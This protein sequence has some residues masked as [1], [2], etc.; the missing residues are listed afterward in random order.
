MTSQGSPIARFRR[1]VAT[2]NPLIVHAAAAEASPLALADALRY[3]LVLA[4]ADPSRYPPA[5]ARFLALGCR[6]L[7][8]TLAD[9]QFAAACLGGLC[10]P[11]RPG[12]G[13][14]L[15]ELLR[16]Q[17]VEAARVLSAWLDADLD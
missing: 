14:G 15:L 9:A 10:A 1:A 12:A 11:R 4:H 16:E 6:E 13:E 7:R 8:W 5:A 3:L 2:G 17:D